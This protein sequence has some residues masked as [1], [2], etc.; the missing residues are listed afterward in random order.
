MGTHKD[1]E[2]NLVEEARHS[3]E[4]EME[5]LVS[6]VDYKKEEFSEYCTQGRHQ[7]LLHLLSHKSAMITI[8]PSQS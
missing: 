8:Q 1:H 2:Y 4:T 6:L 7:I 5:E 3:L